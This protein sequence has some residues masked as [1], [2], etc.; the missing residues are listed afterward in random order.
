[1]K[2]D[3]F[4][5]IDNS[6]FY[7]EG[8][9]NLKPPKLKDIK[10]IKYKTYQLYLSFIVVTYEQYVA[11]EKNIDTS[12]YKSFYE[13][14]INNRSLID[15]YLEVFSFFISDSIIFN[16]EN[17]SFI[18]FKINE[19]DD[20]DEQFKILGVINGENFD[21][22]RLCLAQLNHLSL[23]EIKPATYK[24]DRARKI[25]EKLEKKLL[26]NKSADEGLDL[27]HTISKYCAINT[28]GINLLNVY[29]MSVFQLYEQFGEAQI[30]RKSDVQ[31][32]I[33]A[34]SVSFSDAKSYNSDLWLT[35][36]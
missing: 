25:A 10:N 14:I 23:D 28:S 27:P 3:Y 22:T 20:N 1:M 19:E 12:L 32:L 7:V 2:L 4:D 34:N 21:Y 9:G 8:I 30:I 26:E 6:P 29:E 24:N 16:T 15:I 5:L 36:L 33:Y 31:D 18:I 11:M 17:N 35:K 13:L